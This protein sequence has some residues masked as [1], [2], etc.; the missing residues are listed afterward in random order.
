MYGGLFSE[1]GVRQAARLLV[2]LAVL[3]EAAARRSLPVRWCV[4]A[5]LRYAERVTRHALVE[6]TG[7]NPSDVEQA[8]AIGGGADGRL[9]SASAPADALVLGWRLRALAALFS[10]LLPPDGPAGRAET[11]SVA[12][13]RRLAWQRA[14]SLAMPGGCAWP[15]PDTS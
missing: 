6:E 15:A 10:A 8:L 1:R 2:A 4:L 11:R 12:T 13:P 5:L 14:L 7:W 3:A 9:G